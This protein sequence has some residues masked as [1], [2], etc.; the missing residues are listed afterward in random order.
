[1]IKKCKI[2]RKPIYLQT[3]ILNSM[4]TRIKPN[5]CEISNINSSVNEGIDGFILKEEITM[6]Q[7]YLNTIHVLND[8]LT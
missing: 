1:M 3:N 8:I 4:A 5:F 6:S 7:N 2:M